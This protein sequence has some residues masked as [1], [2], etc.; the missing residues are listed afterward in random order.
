[1][2]TQV[3]WNVMLEL[4][5]IMV[6]GYGLSC[7]KLLDKAFSDKLSWLVVKARISI[8]AA[9]TVFLLI[10]NSFVRGLTASL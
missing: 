7:F 3:V 1:M 10:S 5:I 4:V 2:D 8:P 9:S 6:I